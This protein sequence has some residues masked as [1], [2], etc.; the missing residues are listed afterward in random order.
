[1]QLLWPEKGLLLD[2]GNTLILCTS[3]VALACG[4]TELRL[5]RTL[6]CW[7]AAQNCFLVNA[8]T[9]PSWETQRIPAKCA[10]HMQGQ[11][12]SLRST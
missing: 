11:S 5:I 4:N 1:M 8:I 6:E 3:P 2:I 10:F 12:F 7:S 9:D